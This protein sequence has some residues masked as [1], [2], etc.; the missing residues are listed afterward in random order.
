MKIWYYISLKILHPANA[1]N[2]TEGCI[3]DTYCHHNTYNDSW[4]CT[5]VYIVSI[6]KELTLQISPVHI[7]IYIYVYMHITKYSTRT[8]SGDDKWHL[9]ATA[10]HPQFTLS[11]THFLSENFLMCKFPSQVISADIKTISISYLHT[12]SQEQTNTYVCASN[13]H[14]PYIRG[15]KK[16][17]RGR[18][19]QQHSRGDAP[20]LSCLCRTTQREREK[21]KGRGT[22][23]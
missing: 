6:N 2:V 18:E 11:P 19:G 10:A 7:Y 21:K 4:F 9:C 23:G 1:I 3:I 13:H 17:T 22:G 12:N 16:G 5:R 15:N 20:I 8:H 14:I